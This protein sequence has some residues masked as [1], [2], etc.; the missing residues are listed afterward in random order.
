[1]APPRRGYTDG[2]DLQVEHRLAGWRLVWQRLELVDGGAAAAAAVRERA[3]RRARERYAVAQLAEVPVVAAMRRLFRQAGTDPTRYRPSSEAL[4]RRLLKG[5]E[6]P[7][8]HPLVDVNNCISVALAVPCCVMAEGSIGG[9]VTLRR[10]EVGEG[11]DSLRGPF[12]LEG[13]PLLEDGAGPFGTPI[14]DSHRVAILPLTMRATMVA[15]LPAE[16]PAERV[17]EAWRELALDA[18]ATASP[19]LVTG[20]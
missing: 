19:P 5:E 11:M 9:S 17:A 13:K 20:D 7:A 4:L 14:T 3:T 6:L 10:G 16:S 12:D 1:M 15:Y 8:I 2:V 18:V